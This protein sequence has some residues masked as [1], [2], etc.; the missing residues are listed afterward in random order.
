[1]VSSVPNMRLAHLREAFSRFATTEAL[2]LE[3]PLYATLAQEV[4]ECRELL[5]LASLTHAS[6][7]APNMLFAA[8]QY[9]MLNGVEHSLQQY[10]PRLATGPTLSSD[11]GNTFKSF[12]REYRESIVELIST[13]R[14]QT[15]VVQR[16]SCL[17]A[18]LS[19]VACDTKS[20]DLCLVD[21]GASAGLNLNLDV[22]S[23]CYYQGNSVVHSAGNP[24]SSVRLRTEVRGLKSLPPIQ[25]VSI[26]GRVGI[27]LNPI[28]V[29]DFDSV[30]WLQSL[31]WPEHHERYEQLNRAVELIPTNPVNLRRGDAAGELE[32]VVIEVPTNQA[33]VVCS[34]IA[35]YQF[36][37]KTRNE[38]FGI[39]LSASKRRP[40]WRLSME[41]APESLLSLARYENGT[42]V[43]SSVLA[44]CSPHGLWIEWINQPE[45]H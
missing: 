29:C 14:T 24:Q 28:D 41:G 23:H 10:Y 6:Q 5:E 22:Y 18:G 38:I 17:L 30:L 12:C 25:S 15:N 37:Q 9:L 19:L 45:L 7:P 40:I 33:L 13:R 20:Q 3:S 39:L 11:V 43:Q 8:V 36:P 21:L 4:A 32:D 26:A 16:S 44:K 35:E 2:E 34:T 31:V 42:R 1:M 27:D